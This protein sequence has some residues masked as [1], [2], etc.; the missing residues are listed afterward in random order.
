[1]QFQCPA[2]ME[3]KSTASQSGFFRASLLVAVL[4]S[5]GT[6]SLIIARTSPA[7]AGKDVSLHSEAPANTSQRALSFAERVS[8]QRA[9]EEVYWHHRIWP[10]DNPNPKPSLDAAIS[11]AALEEKVQAYLRDSQA[12]ED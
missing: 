10:K 2:R 4:F 3:K 7:T 5:A 1:M 9:I 6:G 12:L 8:Y 11:Q